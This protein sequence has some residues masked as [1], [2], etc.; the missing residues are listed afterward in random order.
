MVY[1]H[2]AY[3]EACW[4]RFIAPSHAGPPPSDEKARVGRARGREGDT[5]IVVWFL[6][7]PRTGGF[8]AHGNPWA[9]AAA[10]LAVD[11]WCRGE[12]PLSADEQA[13]QLEAPAEA[14]DV[15]LTVEDAVKTALDGTHVSGREV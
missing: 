10:D 11:R 4:Q 12:K 7:E 2:E 1:R 13:A 3:S 14:M 8:L 6:E 9:I 5:E 15:F